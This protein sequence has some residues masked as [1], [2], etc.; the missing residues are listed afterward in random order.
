MDDYFFN[1]IKSH[2]IMQNQFLLSRNELRPGRDALR[3]VRHVPL[4]VYGRAAR[5]SAQAQRND[6]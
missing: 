4:T 6:T 1:E 3:R 2:P 5:L